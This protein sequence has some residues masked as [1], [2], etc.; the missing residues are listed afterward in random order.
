MTEELKIVMETITGLGQAGKEAFVWWLLIKYALYYFTM[1]FFVSA[2]GFVICK[3]ANKVKEAQ[4]DSAIAR[5]VAKEAGIDNEFYL[6]TEDL[7]KCHRWLDTVK[8][9]K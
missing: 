3:I 8:E 5:R 9:R 4:Q 6:N 7:A 2:A 1:I